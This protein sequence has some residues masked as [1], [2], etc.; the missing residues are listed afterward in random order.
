MTMAT[1]H[2]ATAA[3]VDHSRTTAQAPTKSTRQAVII[4]K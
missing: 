1:K 2:M 3:G 4:A